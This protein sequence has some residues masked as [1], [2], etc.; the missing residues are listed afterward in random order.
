MPQ[1]FNMFLSSMPFGAVAFI[2]SHFV[3]R[4]NREAIRRDNENLLLSRAHTTLDRISIENWLTV[5]LC[6]LKLIK[7]FQY[8]CERMRCVQRVAYKPT[9]SP[10]LFDV[11]L[12]TCYIQRIIFSLKHLMR[13]YFKTRTQVTSCVTR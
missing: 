12:T 4:M 7:Y 11:I 1:H 8:V 5:A 6:G 9:K 3:W 10:F 13:L 2:N